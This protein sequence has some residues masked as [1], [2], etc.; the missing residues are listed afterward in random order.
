MPHFIKLTL[1]DGDEHI[2]NTDAI[3]D[4]NEENQ[5]IYTTLTIEFINGIIRLTKESMAHLI[6]NIDWV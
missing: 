4:I 3:L 1:T 2:I 6:A 5:Y